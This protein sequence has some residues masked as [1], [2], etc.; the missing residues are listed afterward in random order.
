MKYQEIVETSGYSLDGS[1]TRDLVFSKLWLAQQ[2]QQI[3]DDRDIA[4]VP[5]AYILGSWYGNLSTILRR[6]GVSIDRIIDV[7]RNRQWLET[8]RQLQQHLGLENIQ[9]M[10]ADANQ[11]DYRQLGNPGVVINTSL[12][13]VKRDQWFDRI[14]PGTIVVLQG[15]DAVPS[16]AAHVY[17]SPD[18]ILDRYPLDPV[19]YQGT[20]ELTDPETDYT[21]SM[22]IGL[23]P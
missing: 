2:L 5:V 10:P 20:M 6:A 15:R 12:N 23:K 19:L 8:G 17:H 3:L 4:T 22:V 13:D 1:W 9:S 18:E 21:R 11:I 14:P 7:E 16:S